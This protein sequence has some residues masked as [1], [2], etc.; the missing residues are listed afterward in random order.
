MWKIF[1]K[2]FNRKSRIELAVK[3]AR[4]LT[5]FSDSSVDDIMIYVLNVV[6][7]ASA[8]ATTLVKNFLTND[9]PTL[10]KAFELMDASDESSVTSENIQSIS[11]AV[12]QM[13][14]IVDETALQTAINK[15]LEDGKLSL[16]EA[17]EILSN[18]LKS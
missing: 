8:T 18:N 4:A 16:V 3:I 14:T 15:A 5:S 13:G 11:A 12:K 10:L 2:L 6:A 1:K 7:P 9:L 17:K